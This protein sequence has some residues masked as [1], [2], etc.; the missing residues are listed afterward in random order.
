M[1]AEL[2]GAID[3]VLE[4]LDR[5]FQEGVELDPLQTILGRMRARGADLDLSNAP[6]LM[7]MLL[8]GMMAS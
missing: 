8:E 7:R 1:Q 3:T 2:D 6:P 5:S 4:V